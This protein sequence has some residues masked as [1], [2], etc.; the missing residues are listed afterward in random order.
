MTDPAAMTGPGHDSRPIGDRVV[1]ALSDGRFETTPGN[2]L[3]G[4]GAEE[5]GALIAQAGRGPDLRIQIN[6]YL[7]QGGG[8]TILIDTGTGGRMGPTAGQLLDNL[9]A[10]GV[11]P[12]QVDTILITHFHGDHT[13]GLLTADDQAAFP[14]AEL[15]VPAEEAAYW[16]DAAEEAAA[17]DAKRPAFAA[18]RAA[19]APYRSRMRII[20]NEAS[21]GIV[22]VPLPGHT[23]GHSGYLIADTLLIWGDIMH[24]PD[25][26]APRPDV[27]VGYDVDPV[28]A[29]RTR[30]D[31]LARAAA[32]RLLVAGMH[33]HFPG[34]SR[35][36]RSGQGYTITPE[37]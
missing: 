21:P 25:V 32:E 33:L 37:V 27:G 24:A 14:R 15:L 3:L 31:I 34:F 36:A 7:V 1:T 22:R 16:L 5:A 10:A 30:H 20:G 8:R 19:S 28:L 12:D 6:A 2:V 17:P 35:I 18:A 11:A 29:A 9:A 4:I 23:P 26:Q 13:G